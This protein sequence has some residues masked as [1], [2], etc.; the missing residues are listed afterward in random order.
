MRG[1]YKPDEDVIRIS[2]AHHR[3]WGGADEVVLTV[4]H[5][6]LHKARPEWGERV[7]RQNELRY[8]RSR[9]LREAAAIRLL[10]VVMFGD[11]WEKLP[12]QHRQ[13]QESPGAD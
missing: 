7:V 2:R 13:H 10:N 12:E 1:Q 4:I 9:A 5:E 3:S 6:A 11:E 8:Y